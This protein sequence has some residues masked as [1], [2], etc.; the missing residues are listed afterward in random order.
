MFPQNL[1]LG[2]KVSTKGKILIVSGI[3]PPDIGG[4]ATYIPQ[5]CRRLV[6]EGFEVSLVSLQEEIDYKRESEPWKRTFIF[7]NSTKIKR[8]FF[9]MRAL[10]QESVGSQAVFANGLYEEVGIL[11]ILRPKLRFV[12]KIVGDPVWERNRNK[13]LTPIGIEDFNRSKLSSKNLIQRL[14]LVWALNRFSHI[15]C[16]SLQLKDLVTGWGVRRDVTVIHN[17][18][19]CREITTEPKQYDV[20]SVSRLVPWK[21]LDV[22]IS[23]CARVNL[24]LAICGEGPEMQRLKETAAENLADV[25]FLGMIAGQK[26]SDV[27]NRSNIFALISSYEG[28]SFALLEAMMAGKRIVVSN[29]KGNADVIRNENNGLVVDIKNEKELDDALIKLSECHSAAARMSMNAHNDVRAKY[30]AEKQLHFMV[31]MI[32]GLDEK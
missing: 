26:V 21:N 6:S 18:I 23:S 8:F 14:I 27:V 29:C 20:V 31:N 19:K 16:P 9:T 30:C 3:Y 4:P 7:R 12:A 22:L 2:Q 25:E 32:V 17:G 15:T 10:Y 24:S 11:K 5:L 28:L 1:N 13:S